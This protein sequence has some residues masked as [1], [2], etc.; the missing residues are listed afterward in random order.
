MQ[1]ITVQQFDNEL[2]ETIIHF[3]Q[4]TGNEA[5]LVNLWRTIED[6]EDAE[7]PIGNNYSEFRCK[8]VLISETTV[9]EMMKIDYNLESRTFEK[10]TGRFIAPHVPYRNDA[11][12]AFDILNESYNKDG[13]KNAFLKKA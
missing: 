5:E 11:Q 7:L 10:H 2:N 12:M 1:F 8:I 9:D 3:L 4:W 6:A 13:F